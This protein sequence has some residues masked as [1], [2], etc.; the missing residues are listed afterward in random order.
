MAEENN[1]AGCQ[2]PGTVTNPELDCFFHTLETALTLYKKEAKTDMRLARLISHN[3]QKRPTNGKAAQPPVPVE[4]PGTSEA[5]VPQPSAS[6]VALP[7]SSH[8]GA[9]F[10]DPVEKLREE[11]CAQNLPRG[12]ALQLIAERMR[13]TTGATGAVIALDNG[14]EVVCC[15]SVGTAPALGAVLQPASGLSGHCMR[16]AEVVICHDSRRDSRVHPA[17][18]EKLE[19]RSALLAP[20]C[21]QA[22]SIGLVGAFSED[23]HTFD[24]LHAA[25]LLLVGELICNIAQGVAEPAAPVTGS[26]EPTATPALETESSESK[27]EIDLLKLAMALVEGEQSEPPPPPD[28]ASEESAVDARC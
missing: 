19:F 28:P 6:P 13:E 22:K 7:P 11:I 8:G 17:V 25:T 4:P 24:Y 16:A 10:T 9:G 3:K 23:P 20:V 18:R 27:G 21:N 5:V 14:Q 15:A 1:P 2:S 26:V 12:A